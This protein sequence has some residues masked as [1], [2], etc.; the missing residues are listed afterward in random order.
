M[1]LKVYRY[2]SQSRT[3]LG[4]L[5]ID[6]YFECYTLEDRHRDIKVMGETRIPQGTYT[7]GLRTEGGH[8]AKYS[9]KFPSFHKGMLHVLDVPNFEYILIHIGNDELDT[10]GCLLVGD[11]TNNNKLQKGQVNS[12]TNAYSNMY[13]KVVEAFEI[14]EP[15]TIQYI[16]L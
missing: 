11:Y 10:M 16:D 3:T 2:S 6:G 12:S 5:H 14:N 1:K 4:A 15:I 9:K 7:V 13:K 8:H